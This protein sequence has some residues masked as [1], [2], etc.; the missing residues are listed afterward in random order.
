MTN[1]ANHQIAFLTANEGVEQIELTAPWRAVEEAGGKPIL[2]AP[3]RGTVRAFNHLDHGDDFHATVASAE[4]SA[5]A[6]AG[7]VL[8]GGVANPDQLRL[9]APA[10]SLVKDFVS[11][12]KPIAVICHGPWTLIEA[13]AVDGRRIT[14][15]PSLRVDLMNAGATWV[16]EPVVVCESGPNVLVSSRKPDDIPAFVQTFVDAFASALVRKS[17]DAAAGTVT[18]N[19]ELDVS[20]NSE[21]NA[22]IQPFPGMNA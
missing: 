21:G 20:P 13:N 16:D 18:L 11:Q 5:D 10:I 1:L 17:T 22:E 6:F 2:I 19:G 12:G 8:P 4:A 15:W 9:D 3:K 7:L 14:S